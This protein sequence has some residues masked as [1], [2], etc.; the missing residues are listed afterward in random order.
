MNGQEI[1]HFI[2]GSYGEENVNL[3]RWFAN[4]CRNLFSDTTENVI[5]CV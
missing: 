1:N 3:T 2:Y 5:K 4:A